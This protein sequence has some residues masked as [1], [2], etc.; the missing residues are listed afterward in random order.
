MLE[1]DIFRQ[2][3]RLHAFVQ[4]TL[5]IKQIPEDIRQSAIFP[6]M[7]MAIPGNLTALLAFFA[8]W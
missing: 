5:K 8:V 3:C 4:N 1:K 6:L 7:F 2:P